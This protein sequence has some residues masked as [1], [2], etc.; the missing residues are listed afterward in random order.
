[1]MDVAIKHKV[2]RAGFVVAGLLGFIV[3]FEPIWAG[4]YPDYLYSRWQMPVGIALL[5]ALAW[6]VL[7]W[8][9]PGIVRAFAG[10]DSDDWEGG[11][12]TSLGIALGI[13]IYVDMA[14][15]FRQAAKCRTRWVTSRIGHGTG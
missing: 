15:L 3:G 11:R 8:C 10:K 2:S 12:G 4:Q 6:I 7:A 13:W 9:E 14:E 5:A 1:M